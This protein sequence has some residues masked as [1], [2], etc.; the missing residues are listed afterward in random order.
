MLEITDAAQDKLQ[1]LMDEQ[2][3]QGYALRVAIA[4]RGP[5]GFMYQLGFVS[6]DNKSEGDTVVDLNGIEVFIDPDT[7]PNIQGS[8]MDYVEDG[9]QNGF[10]IE[11]PNPLWQDPLSMRVQTVLNERVNPALASH[12]GF[13]SLVDVKENKAYVAMG[14]GCQ[15]CGLASVTLNEG[16][17]VMIKDAVPE[18]AEVVDVTNHAMGKN[19]FYKTPEEGKSA[20][21]E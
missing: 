8:T 12:G 14:G 18:I 13:V 7:F 3:K 19:P 15:G 2:D 20:V 5:Q 6:Q 21:S 16:I 1:A 10:S 9:F 4:G 11:N 17:I